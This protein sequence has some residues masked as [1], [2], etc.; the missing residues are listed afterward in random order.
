LQQYFGSNG[1]GRIACGCGVAADL[2]GNMPLSLVTPLA[3]SI[4][5]NRSKM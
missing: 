4:D 2:N 1:D 5:Q 3:A